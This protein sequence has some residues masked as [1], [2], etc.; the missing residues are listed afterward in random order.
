MLLNFSLVLSKTLVTLKDNEFVDQALKNA[1][2]VASRI[3]VKRCGESQHNF[4]R[5]EFA[6]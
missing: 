4:V 1:A 5:N 6:R 3:P 2:D